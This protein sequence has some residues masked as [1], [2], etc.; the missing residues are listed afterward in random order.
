MRGQK[1]PPF[2]GM[3]YQ[4]CPQFLQS[5]LVAFRYRGRDLRGVNANKLVVQVKFRGGEPWSIEDFDGLLKHGERRTPAKHHLDDMGAHFLLVTNAD[6]KGAARNLLVSD[7]EEQ[8]D[9]S[10]FPRSL[11]KTLPNNPEGR[12]AIWGGA[13]SRSTARKSSF[14]SRRSK[15][16]TYPAGEAA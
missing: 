7:F 4:H 1:C 10:E 9:P 5:F 13:I 3:R 15:R 6:A 11:K 2:L 14:A 16:P 8:S 12:V